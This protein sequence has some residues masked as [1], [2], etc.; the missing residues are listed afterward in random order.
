[1]YLLRDMWKSYKK[2]I[3]PDNLQL[4]HV[5]VYNYDKYWICRKEKN[6]QQVWDFK[7]FC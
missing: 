3:V 5:K 1:M 2:S 6:M 4:T 7:V